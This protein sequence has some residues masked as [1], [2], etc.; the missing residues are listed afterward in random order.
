MA[1]RTQ[2]WV[3]LI[4]A[5]AV[6]LAALIG[7]FGPP[8]WRQNSP[9]QEPLGR[10]IRFGIPENSTLDNA[11]QIVG[12]KLN[13][14][15]VFSP[16]CSQKAMQARLDGAQIEGDSKDPAAIIRALLPRVKD[17]TI[18]YEVSEIEPLRRYE[19]RCF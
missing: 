3:A 14:S 2:T 13:V 12:G 11:R 6:I 8:I 18:R 16:V 17:N 10:V 4:G 5:A 9:S 15:V 1:L 19:I 7:T